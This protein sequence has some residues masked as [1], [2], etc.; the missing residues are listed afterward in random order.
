MTGNSTGIDALK[1]AAKATMH[2][3]A[4]SIK[5]AEAALTYNNSLCR[6][7]KVSRKWRPLATA[8]K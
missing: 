4:D 5:K 1:Y 3:A 8:R 6:K 7:T 2:L